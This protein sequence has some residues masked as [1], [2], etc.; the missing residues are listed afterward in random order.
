MG[1]CYYYTTGAPHYCYYYTTGAP[2]YCYYCYF[3]S[4]TLLYLLLNYTLSYGLLPVLYY[5]T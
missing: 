1:Y 5:A 3:W 2:H 4:T